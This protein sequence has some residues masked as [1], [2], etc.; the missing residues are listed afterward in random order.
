MFN[1]FDKEDPKIKLFLEENCSH[2][3]KAPVGD[4]TI[5]AQR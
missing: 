5:T 2:L 1:Y 3:L 4:T